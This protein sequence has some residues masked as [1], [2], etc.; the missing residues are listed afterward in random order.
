M[1]SHERSRR[2]RHRVHGVL[3]IDKPIGVSSASIVT[4]VRKRLGLDRCGHTGTLDPMAT[5]VLPLCLGEGTKL[6]GHL[7]ADDKAYEAEVVLGVETDT[8]DA[9][10]AVTARADAAAAAVPRE[11]ISRALAGFVGA[12]AQ[13]PPMHSA[14]KQDGERLYKMARRG[15]VVERAARDVVIH[16]L[17]LL[18][19]IAA[20]DGRPPR[21]RLAIACSKGTYVRSLAADLGTALG[22]GGHLGALRRTQSG[23]FTLADAVGIDDLERDP[24][25]AL[26]KLV[27]PA[28]ALPIPSVTVPVEQI[29]DVVL[30][31]PLLDI[32]AAAPKGVLFQILT[33][34]GD[35]LALA[36]A[37]P[38][39]RLELCRVFTYGVPTG[40]MP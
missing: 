23:P 25:T 29:R 9:T 38:E 13:V 16:R 15:D 10:G 3:V 1:S 28:R 7:L 40:S 6:A 11:Q 39:P 26:A 19:L 12:I 21:V 14:I 31:L 34:A 22:C 37:H 5:G 18:E 2:G 36:I 8:Y 20:V 35:L 30:G 4:R 17:E 32:A 33:P 27:P 24:A